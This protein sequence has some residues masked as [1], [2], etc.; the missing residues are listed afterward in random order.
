VTKPKINF[1][2]AL[3]KIVTPK[4]GPLGYQK[5]TLPKLKGAGITFFQKHLFDDVYGYVQF[6][7]GRW[8]PTPPGMPPI[9]MSFN[10][11]LIRNI[12]D[13][14]DTIPR[15]NQYYLQMPLSYLLWMVFN[16]HKYGHEYHEWKYLTTEELEAQLQMATDDLVLYGIPWLEDLKSRNPLLKS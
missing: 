15:E 1:Q 9:P 16:V 8:T 5:I 13:E 14:P 7:L 12:G 4:I 10:I 2:L 3:K 6:Q 11:I